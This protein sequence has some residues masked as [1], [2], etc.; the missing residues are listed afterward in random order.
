GRQVTSGPHVTHHDYD[1]T[2]VDDAKI[3]WHKLPTK[4][5]S[6]ATIPRTP[7]EIRA[8]R[9]PANLPGYAGGIADLAKGQT[10]T[11]HLV[12]DKPASNKKEDIQ[13]AT[14]GPAHVSL[15]V[16]EAQPAAKPAAATKDQ[17]KK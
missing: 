6:G 1:L 3:R 13:A 5:S 10:V 16:I 12:R 2:L 9:A 14:A 17:P 7:E 11:V 15:I 8:L 4:D